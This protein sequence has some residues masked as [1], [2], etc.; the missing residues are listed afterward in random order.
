MGER[1]EIDVVAR[2]RLLRLPEVLK[3]VAMG[4]TNLYRKVADGSF[5]KPIRLSERRVRWVLV[6]VLAWVEGLRRQGPTGCVGPELPA[7]QFPGSAHR[8]R[9]TDGPAHFIARRAGDR[10]RG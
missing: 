7:A 4:K 10:R 8:R 5:P 9:S 3:I 1:T 2:S 6:D